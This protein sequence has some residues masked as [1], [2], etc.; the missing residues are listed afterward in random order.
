MANPCAHRTLI[1]PFLCPWH[2]HSNPAINALKRRPELLAWNLRGE[3]TIHAN[4]RRPGSS[5]QIPIRCPSFTTPDTRLWQHHG[6][7][8]SIVGGTEAK[9]VR[10]ENAGVRV[11]VSKLS[12]NMFL[13]SLSHPARS[14]SVTGLVQR[15]PC[16][17]GLR[18]PGALQ[19][20]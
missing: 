5:V 20:L 15:N 8:R 19:I 17:G 6:I 1:A 2:A 13:L 7:V 4:A 3:S 11:T 16:A 14:S 18:F 10:S 12:R 9:G